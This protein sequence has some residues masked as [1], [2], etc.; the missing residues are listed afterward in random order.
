MKRG[1]GRRRK[2]SYIIEIVMVIVLLSA[3]G[4]GVY[5]VLP[6]QATTEPEHI[7]QPPQTQTPE[8]TPQITENENNE[9]GTETGQGDYTHEEEEPYI[10]K[11][12]PNPFMAFSF[13]IPHNQ[14][15]YEDFKEQNP[16]LTYE[17]TVWKV[18]AGLNYLP[19][20][21]YNEICLTNRHPLLVNPRNR[22]S[23]DFVP[24][25]LVFLEG[26]NFR[27]TPETATA[28]ANLRRAASQ[29]GFN[30]WVT[31]AYRDIALQRNL[32][33][34]STDA[35]LARPGHSEHHTGRAVDFGGPLPSGLLDADEQT[36]AGLWLINHSHEFGFIL[37]YTEENKHI[38]SFNSEPWH[39]TYVG[40]DIAAAMHKGGYNSLEEYVAKNPDAQERFTLHIEN[41]EN[42]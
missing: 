9:S 7:P 20:E 18:N 30:L 10:P 29:A 22:L 33:A 6:P 3:M 36:P 19:Y 38:T 35:W 24:Y 23:D 34:N 31:S 5:M 15:M 8:N 14:L 11:E 37:R 13:Y 1:Y 25:R 4:I 27:V 21:N 26:S 40:I 28:L 39:F 41:K 32:H 2:R 42:E 17:E 16:H 12:P